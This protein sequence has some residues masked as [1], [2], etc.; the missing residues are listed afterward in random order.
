MTLVFKLIGNLFKVFFF[1]ANLWREKNKEKAEKKKVIANDITEAF[2][3]T[4]PK[5]RASRLNSAV[6]RIK[7][8]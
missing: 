5:L 2:K 7:R 1:F 6:G 4:D 3:E 8:L